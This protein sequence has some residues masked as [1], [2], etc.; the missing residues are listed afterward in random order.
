MKLLI[1]EDELRLAES[2]I[3][4]LHN[5]GF[6][7]EYSNDLKSAKDKVAIYDYDV[8]LLDLTLPDGNGLELL[9]EIKKNKSDQGV[10]IFSARNSLD[11]KV[12]GLDLGAD[13]YLT[14]PFHLAELKSRINAIIRRRKFEGKNQINF[15]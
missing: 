1:V 9:E 15:N 7:C 10:L 8:I 12:E 5:E 2:I 13:D 14:K 4:Y 11:D 6:V 3:Q